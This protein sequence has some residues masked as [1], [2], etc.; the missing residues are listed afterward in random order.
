MADADIIQNLISRPGQSQADRTPPELDAHFVDIDERTPAD[1]LG[2]A[3][4]LAAKLPFYRGSP[5]DVQGTWAPFFPPA[6]DAALLATG[7]GSV[8]PHLGLLGAFAQLYREPQRVM[9]TLTGRHLDFQFREVLR[10]APRPA[11]PDHAHLLFELKKGVAPVLV[12]AA[13]RL[14]GG[15][16]ATGVELVYAPVRDVVVGAAKVQSLR[17]V[18]HATAGLYFAPV[19]NSADGL[20]AALDPASPK[21]RP[22]GGIDQTPAYVGFGLASPVLRMAEGQRTVT[23]SLQ[24]TNLDLARHTA[25]ALSASLEAH[26]TGPKGWLGPFAVSAAP[27]VGALTLTVVVDDGVAAVVDYDATIHGQSFAAQ[28]PVLQILLKPGAALR[29]DDLA[30][31]CV[32]AT[33][34]RVAVSGLRAAALENDYGSLN[35]KKAFQPFGAQPVVGSRFMIGCEEALGKQLDSIDITV[36]WLAPPSN[37]ATW[38]A[39]YGTS[40]PPA[41]GIS[42]DFVYQDRSGRAPQTTSLVILPNTDNASVTFGTHSPQPAEPREDNVFDRRLFAFFFGGSV[43]SRL[44]GR[45]LGLQ[46]TI[47][48]REVVPPPAA[49]VGYITLALR[50]DLRHAAFR[51]LV[52]AN[53][54]LG[55]AGVD[56]NEPYTP[57]ANALSID[58][59]A[60][61]DTV[62]VGAV[63]EDGYTNLDLQFF[64]VGCFGQRREHAWLRQQQDF[65]ADKRVPLLPEHVAEGELLIGV[66]GVGAG[67]ALSLL[68]QVAEGSADPDLAPQ[69]LAWSVLCD[70]QWRALTPQELVLDTSRDLRAS[71]IVGVNLPVET[72]TENTWLPTGLAWL[73]AT[74]PTSSAAVCQLVSVDAN[75]VEVQLVDQGNDP[76]HLAQPLPAGS[77]AKQKVALAAV[78]TVRQP[79]ASFGGAPGE[80]DAALVRRAAE[81]LRHRNRCITSWDYERM[82]LEAF[83]TVHKVKCIPHASPTSWLAPGSLLIV[84]VPDLR[85][86]NA[87]D[88]LRPHVDIDTLAR[89]ET[90]AAAHAGMQVA[91]TARNPRYQAVQLDFKVRFRAG[92]AYN[93]H[94]QK[95]HD[96]IVRALS[97]WAFDGGTEIEFGG[98]L[99]RSVLLDFVEHRPYVDFVTD[100]RM[101]VLRDDGT[102]PQDAADI[103]ADTPD[104]IL[105]SAAAHAIGPVI[106]A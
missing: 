58:Y 96:E 7:D 84:V 63:D 87:V 6:D 104:A 82:V 56:I 77:I 69:S 37:L 4:T 32:G 19:A 24:L 45:R 93:F 5:T 88:P 47:Y 57:T 106:D 41:A 39:N 42:A 21:W 70:N 50:D 26:L 66:S 14:S 15:K 80:S 49:R 13:Q 91:L 22:F 16:D 10:F 11:T 61:S 46:R 95:L 100:F 65:V 98:R 55:A 52:I 102:A 103:R 36:N 29:F 38:Y 71:G 51:T 74:V 60:H 43:F 94:R 105:V 1:L 81:R 62:D 28:G 12:G 85:N 54:R 3:R 92:Y 2:Q 73:R 53:A 23:A 20:G 64:H 40:A 86:Q 59:S 72:T 27:A 101:G 30:G 17:S 78:K 25:A 76:A 97:P 9:N 89:I 48:K 31:L 83:P 99:Y 34:L 68:A 35:P 33:S 79:Y 90:Y 8:T 75:A 67:D 18:F 44:A